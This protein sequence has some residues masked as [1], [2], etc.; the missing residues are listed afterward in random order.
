MDFYVVPIARSRISPWEKFRRN[1]FTRMT[2]LGLGAA[3]LLATSLWASHALAVGTCGVG[4]VEGERVQ[5]DFQGS[6]FYV[7]TPAEYD[8]SQPWPL[9]LGLHGDEGDPASSVNS[10]WRNVVD[11]RFIFVAP[12]A[13]NESGSWYEEQESNEAWMDA[14][15]QDLLS[16]YNVDLDRVYIWGLSGGAVF[17]SSFALARQDLFAAAQWNMGG[18]PRRNIESPENCKLPARFSTSETDFLHDNAL[19]LFESLTELGH[20]TVWAGADCEEHCWDDVQAGPAARDWLLEHTHCG[21]V[22]TLG[23]QDDPVGAGGA[24]VGGMGGAGGMAGAGTGGLAGS[25]ADGGTAGGMGGADSGLGGA[26]AT[27]G[28][29][30]GVGGAVGGSTGGAMV[31]GA[32]GAGLGGSAEP[33]GGAAGASTST[34]LVSDD[35]GCA[36]SLPGES[37]RRGAP[38]GFFALA[39]LGIWKRRRRS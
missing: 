16:K 5:V 8:A 6:L 3:T 17:I 31:G 32:S 20:E 37:K 25:G 9:I 12:K 27:G 18:S 30:V 7:T 1:F 36:C 14:V 22:P 21:V 13:A 19:S 39:L 38:V 29:G 35:P 11:G 33:M 28:V 34:S 15:V 23:C 26:V 24:G 4:G 10:L 2:K